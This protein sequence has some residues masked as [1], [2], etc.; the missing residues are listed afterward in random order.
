MVSQAHAVHGN[1]LM[2]EAHVLA[3]RNNSAYHSHDAEAWVSL[4]CGIDPHNSFILGQVARVHD[5]IAGS[6]YAALLG[7]HQ[8]AHVR[9]LMALDVI[10]A[11]S[12]KLKGN[13]C[14]T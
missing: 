4:L 5:H 13:S 6:F 7:G 1:S 12:S 2:S 8:R 10:E 11:C 9:G 3:G 14:L